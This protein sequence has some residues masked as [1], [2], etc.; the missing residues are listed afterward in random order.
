MTSKYN[1]LDFLQRSE[2]EIQMCCSKLE[3]TTYSD[4]G[5]L[6]MPAHQ[7]NYISEP[8]IPLMEILF[9]KQS[10]LWECLSLSHVKIVRLR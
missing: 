1:H 8:R 10:L 9:Y 7:Y 3:S 4:G 6:R 5:T 2:N